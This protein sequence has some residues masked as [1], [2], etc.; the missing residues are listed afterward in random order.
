MQKINGKHEQ[1]EMTENKRENK[2]TKKTKEKLRIISANPA[3]GEENVGKP[4]KNQWKT[5]KK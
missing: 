2:E 5:T 4:M 1:K 3:Q